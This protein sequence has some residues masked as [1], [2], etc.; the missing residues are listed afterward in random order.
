MF[1]MN[2]PWQNT[3]LKKI[4]A[5][6]LKTLAM[7]SVLNELKVPS[8][9]MF[10]TLQNELAADIRFEM[11]CQVMPNVVS[12]GGSPRNDQAG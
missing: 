12:N 7:Q 3:I 5:P 11:Y 1:S 9:G 10:E 2:P 8:K 6:S 4:S